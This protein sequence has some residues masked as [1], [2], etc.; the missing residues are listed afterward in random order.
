MAALLVY[1]T[2]QPP[3]QVFAPILDCLASGT[4]ISYVQKASARLSAIQYIHVPSEEVL[5]KPTGAIRT[6]LELGLLLR[7]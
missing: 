4:H 7:L 1:A 2:G 5:K 6:T 3:F